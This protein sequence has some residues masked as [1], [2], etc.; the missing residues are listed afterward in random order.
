MV[1]IHERVQEKI[2]VS[3]ALSDKVNLLLGD[4]VLLNMFVL[5]LIEEK[6]KE[7]YKVSYC[8]V[9][10]SWDDIVKSAKSSD[11][12]L[13]ENADL[14]MFEEKYKALSD[15]K[16]IVVASIK[17]YNYNVIKGMGRYL[18]EGVSTTEVISERVDTK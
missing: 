11:I 8:N 4:S 3:I 15:Y 18:V 13:L 16:S 10:T 5:P 7:D 1:S 6:Y 12:L 14:Y 17:E 2:D 9:N